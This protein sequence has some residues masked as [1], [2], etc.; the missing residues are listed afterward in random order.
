M[1]AYPMVAYPWSPTHGSGC[2]GL[3]RYYPMVQDG[4]PSQQE[5][6]AEYEEWK[7]ARL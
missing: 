1:V 4:T 6:W 5:A 2:G 7:K 3:R